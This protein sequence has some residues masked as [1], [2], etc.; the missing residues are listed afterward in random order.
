[1]L[2]QIF[3]AMNFVEPITSYIDGTL[4][5][6]VQPGTIKDGDIYISNTEIFKVDDPYMVEGE[7]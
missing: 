6:Y 4:Y 2:R 3:Q 7:G 1:M 5:D